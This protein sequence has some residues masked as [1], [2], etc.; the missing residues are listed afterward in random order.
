MTAKKA[1][2]RLCE[3]RGLKAKSKNMHALNSAFAF[4]LQTLDF[5]VAHLARRF[6]LSRALAGIVASLVWGAHL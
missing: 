3:G 5:Q 1:P 2:A 4:E 6:G